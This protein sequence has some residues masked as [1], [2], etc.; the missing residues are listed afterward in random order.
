[1]SRPRIGLTQRV[2]VVEAYGERRDCL[3]Q[4]WTTLLE[5]LDLTPIPLPN[6]TGNPSVYLEDATLDGLILTSGNDLAHLEDA[7][8]PAP[9]R[10]EFEIAGLEYA[11]EHEIPV[12]GVCRGLQLLV[13]YYG[14]ELMTVDGHVAQDHDLTITNTEDSA[15]S[16]VE[17]PKT[18]RV[19]SYHDYG[20]ATEEV[21]SDLSVFATAPDGTVELV[22]HE[23]NDLVGI[24]WHPE[25]ESPSEEL[26]RQI[27]TALFRDET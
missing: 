11:I 6:C 16:G 5:S 23:T 21:T 20:I 19:N 7:V 1:M 13:H 17:L 3:D 26:D 14:G 25:R 18:V 8:V 4:Q 2:D 9:E 12:L 10:D 15:I 27:L 24:M 22:A